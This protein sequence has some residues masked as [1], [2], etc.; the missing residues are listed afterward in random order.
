MAPSREG[1]AGPSWAKRG[2]AQVRRRRRRCCWPGGGRRAAA[3]CDRYV[4][5]DHELRESRERRRRGRIPGVDSRVFGLVLEGS[6]TSCEPR[7]R[8]S[9]AW[10]GV[11]E[12]ARGSEIKKNAVAEDDVKT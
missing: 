7:V 9:G 12:R 3:R 6:S 1:H 10:I 11:S 5:F 8:R 2:C 4:R